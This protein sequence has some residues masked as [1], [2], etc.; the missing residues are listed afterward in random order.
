MIGDTFAQIIE[1]IFFNTFINTLVAYVYLFI[2]YIY[3]PL[4]AKCLQRSRVSP[5][6]TYSITICELNWDF[7]V[8]EKVIQMR[9]IKNT[10]SRLCN[11][12]CVY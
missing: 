8:S 7:I 6:Q 3:F 10:H 9:Y 11:D 5:I 1:Y 2:L 4:A 12:S